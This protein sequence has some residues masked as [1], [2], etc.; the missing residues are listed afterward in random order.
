MSNFTGHSLTPPHSPP[1]EVAEDPREV[2]L[3]NLADMLGPVAHELHNV[4]NNIVL[5][6]AIVSRSAPEALRPQLAEFRALGLRASEMLAQLDQQRHTIP[7]PLQP[8]DL[9]AVVRAVVDPLRAHGLAVTEQLS[10]QP[11]LVLAHERDLAR[12]LGLLVKGAHLAG[13]PV[14]V[15]T[16]SQG[17]KAHLLVTD[18]RPPLDPA[19]LEQFFEPFGAPASDN[20][21]ER[22]ACQTLAR[23]LKATLRAENRPNVT[24]VVVELNLFSG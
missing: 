5:Q 3:L 7:T 11:S 18:Q 15:A 1:G 24:V 4:F 21:L 9:H 17:R 16:A 22:A 6:A 2:A 23:R 14:V 20:P 8:V 12:L 13:P 19:A 10:A